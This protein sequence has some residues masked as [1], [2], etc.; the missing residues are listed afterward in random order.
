M[1]ARWQ[2]GYKC[3]ERQ[4]ETRALDAAKWSV[5]GWLGG[6]EGN[7]GGCVSGV[8]VRAA[9]R[10]G[11]GKELRAPGGPEAAAASSTHPVAVPSASRSPSPCHSQPAAQTHAPPFVAHSRRHSHDAREA[12]RVVC[13][14][15]GGACQARAA[16][17]HQVLA[18][19]AAADLILGWETRAEL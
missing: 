9:A 7:H 13:S 2:G 3:C 11:A 16:K 19:K 8:H 5:G 1:G 14:E 18:W 17:P 6:W 10:S 12:A 4:E 15:Q